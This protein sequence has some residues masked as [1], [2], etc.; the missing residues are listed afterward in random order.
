MRT[1]QEIGGELEKVLATE[2]PSEKPLQEALISTLRLA[3][4]KGERSVMDLWDQAIVFANEQ[5]PSA[6]RE[7]A[8]GIC[9]CC[10]WIVQ[11]E[12]GCVPPSHCFGWVTTSIP[13]VAQAVRL[14]DP[15]L[16]LGDRILMFL[17]ERMPKA[18]EPGRLR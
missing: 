18:S 12:H 14:M 10:A 15:S 1:D 16:S 17:H 3:L 2:A 5:Q 6:Q 4:E 7:I 13:E 8:R 11:W 9:T